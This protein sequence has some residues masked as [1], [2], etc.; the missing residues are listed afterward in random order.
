MLATM[1]N[2]FRQVK[3]GFRSSSPGFLNSFPFEHTDLYLGDVDHASDIMDP[4]EKLIQ[5]KCFEEASV[6]ISNLEK[7]KTRFKN[8]NYHFSGAAPMLH[9]PSGDLEDDPEAHIK[10]LPDYKNW[11]K[12]RPDCPFAAGTLALALGQTGY[13]FRGT[14][15]AHKVSNE[16]WRQLEKYSSAA[17]QIFQRHHEQ[18][19]GHWYWHRCLFDF[20][21]IEGA[22]VSVQHKRFEDCVH[23]HPQ[24]FALYQNRAYQLLPR[25]YGSYEE[26][27]S[28][29]RYCVTNT[30]SEFG[31]IGYFKTYSNVLFS[32][33]FESLLI[34]SNDLLSSSKAMYARAPEQ[35]YLTSLAASAIMADDV[36]LFRMIVKKHMTHFCETSW[37]APNDVYLTYA[38]LDEFNEFNESKT[39]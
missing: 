31:N 37:F 4:I 1:K 2:S 22:E 7:R 29:A 19:N 12:K 18:F 33:E 28:L 23:L 39:N 16:G 26:V 10:A 11:Y 32:E 14:D 27:E 30:K 38:L 24:D 34:D 9:M 35:R 13:S 6:E 36:D 15:W 21:L 3:A 25:W 17:S 8:A 20:S 5:S